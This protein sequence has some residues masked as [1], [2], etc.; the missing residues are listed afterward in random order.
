MLGSIF[1][2]CQKLVFGWEMLW[3]KMRFDLR[4]RW[5]A[6]YEARMLGRTV[7]CLV[8][9]VHLLPILSALIAKGWRLVGL[10]LPGHV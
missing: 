4:G 7:T 8:C 2:Q 3:H 10:C 6:V 5:R 9:W 1:E